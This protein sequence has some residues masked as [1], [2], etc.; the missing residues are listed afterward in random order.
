VTTLTTGLLGVAINRQEDLND[1]IIYSLH[2]TA[3]KIMTTV[4]RFD[5]VQNNTGATSTD[6]GR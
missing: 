5:I 4:E 3:T 2:L 1:Y 6:T